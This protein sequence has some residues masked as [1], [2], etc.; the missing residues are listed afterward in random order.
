[1]PEINEKKANDAPRF[2]LKLLI[3]KWLIS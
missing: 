2:L 3:K 1:L